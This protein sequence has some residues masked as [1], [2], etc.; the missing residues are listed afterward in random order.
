MHNQRAHQPFDLLNAIN[1][2]CNNKGCTSYV[3]SNTEHADHVAYRSG[4]IAPLKMHALMHGQRAET[5]KLM[6][7]GMMHAAAV[8]GMLKQA[9]TCTPQPTCKETWF[10]LKTLLLQTKF[11]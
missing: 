10:E 7:A 5:I 8:L 1:S 2:C 9:P 4:T 11:G 3:G 6:E